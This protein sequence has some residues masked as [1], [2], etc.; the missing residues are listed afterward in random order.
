MKNRTKRLK[1]IELTLTPQQTAL[2]WLANAVKYTFADGARQFPRTTIANSVRKAVT[3]SMK[4]ESDAVVERAILQGRQEADVL[5]NLVITINARVLASTS[6]RKREYLFLLF[7]LRGITN[8]NIGPHSEEELR[9]IVLFFV[10]EVLLL[11]GAI[12][13]VSAEHFGSQPILFSDS[14]LKLQEQLDLANR[15]LGYF[16]QLAQ[17]LNFKELTAESVRE[18]LGTD[19]TQQASRW[20]HLARFQMLVDFGDG[21]DCR[22]AY[23]Q[24]HA[25]VL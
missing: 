1:T 6:E 2:L 7:Y 3:H 14:V 5:F 4:S 22:A 10:E 12:S 15:A 16:N 25:G 9:T 18:T 20:M 24:I 11:D 17:K 23:T 13:Q 19:I 21:A 8:I